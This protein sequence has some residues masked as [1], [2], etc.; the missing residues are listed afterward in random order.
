MTDETK[1]KIY[2]AGC[3]EECLVMLSIM[4]S[5]MNTNLSAQILMLMKSSFPILN[6]GILMPIE[7]MSWIFPR[8]ICFI[9]V[10]T[11]IWDIVS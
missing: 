11:P 3:A 9:L 6:S 2:I 5:A 8:T 7:K 1:K 10:P 4:S